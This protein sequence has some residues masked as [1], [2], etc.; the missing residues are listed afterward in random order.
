MSYVF[1]I[2]T[3]EVDS[4]F[5]NIIY[6]KSTPFYIMNFKVLSKY[7]SMRRTPFPWEMVS[8]TINCILNNSHWKGVPNIRSSPHT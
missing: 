7:L 3:V 6:H 8:S 1:D 4:D 5:K 2:G